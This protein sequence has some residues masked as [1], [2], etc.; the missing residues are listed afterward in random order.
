MTFSTDFAGSNGRKIGSGPV[1]TLGKGE[2]SESLV[3]K[4][5]ESTGL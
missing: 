2:D 5:C 4:T 1:G 3:H